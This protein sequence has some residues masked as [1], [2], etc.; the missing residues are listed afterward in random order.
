MSKVWYITGTS[1]GLGKQWA[2]HALSQGDCVVAASRNLDDLE[3]MSS[4]VKKV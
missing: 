1:R 3:Y 2:L 4:A